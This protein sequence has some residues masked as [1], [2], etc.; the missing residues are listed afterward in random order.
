[1]VAMTD[2]DQNLTYKP[3]LHTR[4]TLYLVA[5]LKSMFTFFNPTEYVIKK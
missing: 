3:I 4:K 2:Q 5:V 1:M